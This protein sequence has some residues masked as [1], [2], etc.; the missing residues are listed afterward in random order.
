MDRVLS[1]FLTEMDGIETGKPSGNVAV[2]GITH[3]AELIDPSL[4]RPGRLEKTISLGMPDTE[5]RKELVMREILKMNLDFTS[6]DYFDPKNKED[7]SKFVA[8]ESVGMSAVEVIA[9]CKEASM[10]YLREIDFATTN[11]AEPPSLRYKHFKRAV[12]KMKG[13]EK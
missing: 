10:E 11:L 8:V 3:D 1:M 7:L 2:I 13:R 9:I 4:R 5:A 6:A 12:N